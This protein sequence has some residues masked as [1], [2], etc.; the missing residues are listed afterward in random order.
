MH[1]IHIKPKGIFKVSFL[2][3]FLGEYGLGN[4]EEGVVARSSLMSTCQKAMVWEKVAQKMG[5]SQCEVYLDFGFR[6]T[7]PGV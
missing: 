6:V 2:F 1:L 3:R 7:R 4:L 5:S